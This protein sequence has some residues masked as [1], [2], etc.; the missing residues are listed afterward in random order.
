[1]D[2]F[3]AHP[4]AASPREA[5]SIAHSRRRVFEPHAQ[6]LAHAAS[7]GRARLF[8]DL[9][10][11]PSWLTSQSGSNVRLA[12]AAP[13]LAKSS[14]ILAPLS[15]DRTARQYRKRYADGSPIAANGA[16]RSLNYYLMAQSGL[17]AQ[18]ICE[19]PRRA[20]PSRR[21]HAVVRRTACATPRAPSGGGRASSDFSGATAR[22]RPWSISARDGL[23]QSASDAPVRRDALSIPPS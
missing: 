4:G 3:N 20:C 17:R 9:V 7:P 15:K 18:I 11:F 10:Q 23:Q 2:A 13:V 8:F 21:Y 1:M 19:Q 5:D 12:R 16:G 6:I 22:S 14:P